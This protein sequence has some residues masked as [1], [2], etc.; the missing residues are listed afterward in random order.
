MESILKGMALPLPDHEYIR[1]MTDNFKSKYWKK[2]IYEFYPELHWVLT[3]IPPLGRFT[4]G[5]E[6]RITVD[7]SKYK[8]EFT[9][10]KLLEDG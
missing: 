10:P 5:E 6:D 4:I 9:L 2:R 3:P 1:L 8:F 7:G